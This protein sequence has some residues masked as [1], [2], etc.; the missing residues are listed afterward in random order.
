MGLFSGRT[1][2]DAI[3]KADKAES[4]SIERGGGYSDYGPTFAGMP[5]PPEAQANLRVFD[6]D[7]ERRT[8]TLAVR[9]AGGEIEAQK[10]ATGL[11]LKIV[12]LGNAETKFRVP[13]DLNFKE[14]VSL[15][16]SGSKKGSWSW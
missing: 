6:L 7:P 15:A 2:A 16:K 11:G 8:F 5:V 10:L 1:M 14:I 13:D 3:R 9:Q 12:N 4:R